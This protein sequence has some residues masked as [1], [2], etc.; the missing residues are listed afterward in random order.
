MS[1]QKK[2]LGKK[3]APAWNFVTFS[4][5]FLIVI[6]KDSPG[7]VQLWRKLQGTRL[8]E[9]PTYYSQNISKMSYQKKVLGKK[10]A[11]A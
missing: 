5:N 4:I 6:R 2:V 11:P 10:R 3:R 8:Q 1:Y 9:S 7:V